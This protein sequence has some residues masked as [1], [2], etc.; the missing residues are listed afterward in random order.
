MELATLCKGTIVENACMDMVV[1]M[2][3]CINKYMN[4]L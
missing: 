3:L 2:R 1:Y 4:V